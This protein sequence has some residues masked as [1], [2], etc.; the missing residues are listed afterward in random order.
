VSNASPALD[1][2]RELFKAAVGGLLTGILTP[3]MQLAI[4]VVARGHAEY[5]IG[6]M[7][8]PFAALV[9]IVT[10]MSGRSWWVA[11]AAAAVTVLAFVW[12]VNGAIWVNAY[13]FDLGKFTRDSVAGLAGGFIGAATMAIGIALLTWSRGGLAWLPM[14]VFG[15]IAGSLLAVDNTLDL[16]FDLATLSILFPVWQCGVAAGL[17][18]AL[19]RSRR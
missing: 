11:A 7:A 16:T 17:M 19:Q 1:R 10:R 4:D 5:R 3:L 12:A 8:L 2:L 9:L 14:L 18:L 13:A 6:L 15:T